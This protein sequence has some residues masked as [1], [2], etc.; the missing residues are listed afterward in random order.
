MASTTY[1][2]ESA[3][4][5]L[6]E[7]ISKMTPTPKAQ[8]KAPKVKKAKKEEAGSVPKDQEPETLKPTN[9]TKMAA[10]V[11]AL[12]CDALVR[13]RDRVFLLKVSEDYKIPFEELEAK[14]L[15]TA[16]EAIKVPKVRKAKVT[17][18]GANK[19]QAQTAKK[20][21]CSFSALKGEC[22]C[23]RHLAQQNA[24][25]KPAKP[26]KEPKVKVTKPTKVEPTHTHEPSETRVDDCELCESHGSA[27]AEEEEFEILMSE[28]ELPPAVS[29]AQ[30]EEDM[31]AESDGEYDDE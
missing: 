2:T 28:D 20:G 18:E 16:E 14:Y 27:L 11:F 31:L 17:V 6:Q 1:F 10:S 19:C 22:F 3:N 21:P 4:A 23:K 26:A 9:N 30:A 25:P 13:E 7:H 8:I 15:T 24:E 29:P 12:A 5:A